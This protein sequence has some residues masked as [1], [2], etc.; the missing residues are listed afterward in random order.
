MGLLDFAICA[1]NFAKV[2]T[3]NVYVYKTLHSYGHVSIPRCVCSPI[4]S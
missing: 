4:P 3:P 1:N 2:E